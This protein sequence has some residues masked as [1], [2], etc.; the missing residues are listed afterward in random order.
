MHKYRISVCC[1]GTRTSAT[2]AKV[3][4]KP[5]KSVSK[6]L[7]VWWGDGDE[8]D[9]PHSK[10]K[11]AN[12]GWVLVT[13]VDFMLLQ[14]SFTKSD[15]SIHLNNA[16]RTYENCSHSLTL[17]CFSEQRQ[18]TCQTFGVA[19]TH[20]H[21]AFMMDT[22]ASFKLQKHTQTYTITMRRVRTWYHTTDNRIQAEAIIWSE[23]PSIH[24]WDLTH[25]KNFVK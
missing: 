5:S 15:K 7:C 16:Y 24:I 3:N 1:T 11:L 12:E 2:S 6:W 14:V 8:D 17:I 4:W 20:T 22:R 13:G 21:I 25:R 9:G 18:F 10:W 23:N 19:V